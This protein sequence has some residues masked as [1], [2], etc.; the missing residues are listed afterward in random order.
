MFHYASGGWKGG[1]KE[2]ILKEPRSYC[3]R[4]KETCKFVLERKEFKLI[5]K[6]HKII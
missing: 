3:G 2:V 5:L 4:D 6:N 1:L